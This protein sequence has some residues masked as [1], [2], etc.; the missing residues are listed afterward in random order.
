MECQSLLETWEDSGLSWSE[1][2]SIRLKLL[3]YVPPKII[4]TVMALSPD[5]IFVPGDTITLA[6][7]FNEPVVVTA[8]DSPLQAL[9]IVGSN[10]ALGAIRSRQRAQP[11]RVPLHGAG[12]GPGRR[13]R[14]DRDE[15]PGGERRR[16]AWAPTAAAP[17]AR[18]RRG[19][20]RT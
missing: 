6:V 16:R 20:T 19:S 13:R 3:A 10:R 1:G 8:G 7:L 18:W 15:R 11:A 2:D 4:T 12:G 17:S 5:G 9:L 14:D